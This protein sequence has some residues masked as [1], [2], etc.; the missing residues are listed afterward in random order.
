MRAL[1]LLATLLIAPLAGASPF[2]YSRVTVADGIYAF[3]EPPGHAVVSGNTVAIV[4]E[5]AVA[6]VD[7]GQHPALTRRIVEEIRTLTAKPVAYVVNTHWHNDHV[8][9]NAIFAEAFPAARFIAH[10]FTARLMD[11]ETRVYQEETCQGFLRTQSQPLRDALAKGV[12]PDGQPLAPARRARYERFLA[13]ADANLAECLE[14]RFRGT[15]IAFD[16]RLTLRLGKRDVQVM[17]LGRAN[18]AGDSVVMVP[19]ANVAI[20]GDILVHPFPFAFQ[21]YIGEWAAVLRRIEAMKPAVIVPGH[22]PVMRDTRY[23]VDV[24][25]LMESIDAQVR[26]AYKP[27]MTLEEVRKQVDLSRFRARIAGDD[28]FLQANF[29]A[30]IAGSAVSRA[31]QQAVGTLEPE[32]LPRS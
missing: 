29:D 7:T 4:G 32:G 19:D 16:E 12:A 17:Y 27:G 3:I 23:L 21:S 26:S 28:P 22:G 18:T 6:V 9:G 2:S 14:Y 30:G 1:L 10:S 24:A 5:D 8:A 25:E 15:D 20:V 11:T 13:D 31:Y